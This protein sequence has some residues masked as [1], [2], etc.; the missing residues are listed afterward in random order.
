MLKNP[1]IILFCTA[2]KI[3]QL[4]FQNTFNYSKKTSNYSQKHLIKK[5]NTNVNLTMKR[6]YIQHMKCTE[7]NKSKDW[8]HRLL[9]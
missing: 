8:S 5:C 3:D 9:Y 7:E 1:P 4:L 6:H 2:N